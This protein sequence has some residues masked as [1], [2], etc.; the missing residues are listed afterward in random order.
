MDDISLFHSFSQRDRHPVM[1]HV[2]VINNVIVLEWLILMSPL[3]TTMESL[4]DAEI[5]YVC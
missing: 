5:A 2:V 3:I 1:S 4:I